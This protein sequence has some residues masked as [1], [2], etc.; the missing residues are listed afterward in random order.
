MSYRM[1]EAIASL[2]ELVKRARRERCI[3]A[4]SAINGLRYVCIALTE[5]M[6]MLATA[7][8]MDVAS[9]INSVV[10]HRA[11]DAVRW[12]LTPSGIALGFTVVPNRLSVRSM[13][14]AEPITERS[15]VVAVLR[16]PPD[17]PP[18]L[19][20]A[21]LTV[22]RVGSEYVARLE[23]RL[24]KSFSSTATIVRRLLEDP[25]CID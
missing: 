4:E 22:M 1:F 15:I 2:A 16:H 17:P 25:L 12:V 9:A 24:T 14:D 5:V 23:T 10:E 21:A 18:R 13:I 20:G 11:R 19:V 6:N 8:V 7:S 3:S